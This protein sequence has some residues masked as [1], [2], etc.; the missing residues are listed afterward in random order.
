MTL[1]S[2]GTQPNTFFPSHLSIYFYGLQIWGK[3][4]WRLN[5]MVKS[6][7]TFAHGGKLKYHGNLPNNF[8]P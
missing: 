6:F 5:T 7:I 8:N 2:K 1:W 4:K 3:K